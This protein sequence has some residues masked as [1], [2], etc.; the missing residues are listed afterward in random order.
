MTK[1]IALTQPELLFIATDG[2]VAEFSSDRVYRYTLRRRWEDRTERHL[3]IVWLMFNPSTADEV[4]NDPTIRKCIGFSR[5]W[6]YEKLVI[7]NLYAVRNSDPRVLRFVDDPVGPENDEWIRKSLTE[8]S[9]VVCAWGCAQHMPTI[10]ARIKDVLKIVAES[11]RRMV[12]LG[13]RKDH[14][15]RHPLMVSYDTQRIPYKIVNPPGED[16]KEES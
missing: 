12:C 8:A 2:C 6:G 1:R 11:G 4:E 10:D 5:R 9:E 14:H 13:Y 15:P 16:H 3:S 7:L